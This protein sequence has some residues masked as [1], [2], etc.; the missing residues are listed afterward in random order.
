[1][2]EGIAQQIEHARMGEV[3]VVVAQS[4]TKTSF[5]SLDPADNFHVDEVRGR[6]ETATNF[7]NTEKSEL[8]SGNSNFFSHSSISFSEVIGLN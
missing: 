5:L 6:P 4:A 2:V 1:L 8:A 7:M 3:V